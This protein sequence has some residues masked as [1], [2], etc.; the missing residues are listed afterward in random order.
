MSVF[1][2]S[3]VQDILRRIA[4]HTAQPDATKTCFGILA[5]LSREDVNKMVIAR[6]GLEVIL[7]AMTAHIDKVDVQEAGCDLIWSLAFNSASVKEVIAKYGGASV[8][9]RALKRHGK[10][11]DYMKSACGALSN[12]CQSKMNQEAVA[13]YGGL[14]PLV[15][16]IHTHQLNSKLLPFVFDAIASLVVT[17]EDNARTVSSLGVV[18]LVIT[19]LGRHK[20]IAEVVKSGCHTL[21]ILSDVKGQAS[22]IAFA[23]GVPTILVLLDIHPEYSD[24]HRVAAVVLLRMLQESAHVGREIVCHEGIRIM[25]KSLN[26]GGAR[27]DTVAAVTHILFAVT[28]PSNQ[29]PA[30]IEPQLWLHDGSDSPTDI[31]AGRPK[32]AGDGGLNPIDSLGSR[33]LVLGKD[34]VFRQDAQSGH[35]R[36][37]LKGLVAVLMQYTVRRDVARAACRLMNNLCEYAGVAV[38]LD[39]LHILDG[40]LECVGHHSDSRDVTES[41]TSI[42][43]AMNRRAKPN[44]RSIKGAAIKG[45][46]NLLTL[47]TDDEEALQVICEILMGIVNMRTRKLSSICSSTGDNSL[48]DED[49][50]TNSMDMNTNDSNP[51]APPAGAD[52][53]KSEIITY[54]ENIKNNAVETSTLTAI[55][56]A[57]NY[58]LGNKV[59]ITPEP[60][61]ESKR[62]RAPPIKQPFSWG[63]NSHKSVGSLVSLLESICSSKRLNGEEVLAM[64]GM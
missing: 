15:G 5:I 21:A 9:V 19:S 61:Q 62:S 31:R 55:I 59:D 27:Q 41:V 7:S 33:S 63:K 54:Y 52:K 2:A 36:T 24:L 60:L 57:I 40:V 3:R 34:G 45:L 58:I 25:L 49:K 32:K 6:E 23:G 1:P 17:N 20:N 51:P 8:V 12:M 28:S 35:S 44:L 43:K 50:S 42:L 38:T 29:S 46:L 13:S 30:S 64:H 14:Q 18:P 39:S 4:D 26:A 48:N 10:S 22:K 37:A 11:A 56:G 16:A 53:T 47:K